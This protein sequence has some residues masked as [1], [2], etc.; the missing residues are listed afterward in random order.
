LADNPLPVREK[1]RL[2][3]TSVSCFWLH[4]LDASQPDAYPQFP[5]GFRADKSVFHFPPAKIDA[6]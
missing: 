6:V 2:N 5:G 3:L 1:K 4:H